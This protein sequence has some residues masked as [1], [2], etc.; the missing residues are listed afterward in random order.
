MQKKRSIKASLNST[1][2][3]YG[4]KGERTKSRELITQNSAGK[5]G[6]SGED[7]AAVVS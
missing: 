3:Y 2:S 4:K 1:L 5:A 6:M 7:R